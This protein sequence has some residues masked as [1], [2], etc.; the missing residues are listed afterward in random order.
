MTVIQP[1]ET[2]IVDSDHVFCDGG[3]AELG[4]PRIYMALKNGKAD[5]GYCGRRFVMDVKPKVA[6]H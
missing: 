4:H 5:C 3:V 6:A 2:I 1:P